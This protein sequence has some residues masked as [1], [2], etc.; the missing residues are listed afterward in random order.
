MTSTWPNR[1]FFWTGTVRT[2]QD[3]NAKAEMRNELPFGGGKWPTFPELLEDAGVPWKIYQNDVSCG[4]GFSG[5][6]R[7]WLASLSCN[8]SERFQKYNVQFS[9]RYVTN[10]KIKADKL[11]KEIDDLNEKR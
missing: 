8:P 10:P 3:K 11:Q 2:E 5:E 1:F 9:D 7:S 4:G 6:E